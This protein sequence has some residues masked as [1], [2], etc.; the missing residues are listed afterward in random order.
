MY[1]SINL[2][3]IFEAYDNPHFKSFCFIIGLSFSIKLSFLLCSC[4]FGTILSIYGICIPSDYHKSNKQDKF[5][6]L[7]EWKRVHLLR[8]CALR[9]LK[10]MTVV[11]INKTTGYFGKYD[12]IVRECCYF[13]FGGCQE[14]KC[15]LSYWCC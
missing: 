13:S 7:G 1:I 11:L 6:F 3:P 10:G 2:K 8:S 14:K 9:S 12:K 15:D 5:L 4:Y